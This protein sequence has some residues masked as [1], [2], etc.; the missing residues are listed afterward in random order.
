M[1]LS[2]L[3]GAGTE[4]QAAAQ[5]LDVT[6]RRAAAEQ[7]AHRAQHDELTGLDQTQHAESG[8]ILDH[9]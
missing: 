7:L 2:A 1:S 8:Y 6:E 5:F 3:T 4:H 9:A